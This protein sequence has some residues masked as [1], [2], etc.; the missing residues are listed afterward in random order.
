LL[1]LAVTVGFLGIAALIAVLA[2]GARVL[3]E[4]DTGLTP[5]TIAL[6]GGLAALLV[7]TWLQD[8]HFLAEG[9]ARFSFYRN[10][11]LHIGRLVCPAIVIALVLPFPIPVAWGLAMVGSIVMAAWMLRAMPD[12]RASSPLADAPPTGEPEGQAH[13]PQHR[14]HVPVS[15]FLGTA[16]RNITGSAAEFLPGLLLPPLVLRLQGAEPSAWFYIAWTGASMLFLLSASI[17]R[18]T[19]AEMS[20]HGE[21]AHARYLRQALRHHKLI[22]LPA[23]VLALLTAPLVLRLFGAS[24]LQHGLTVFVLLASSIV[25]IVPVYLYLA[26][27]RSRDEHVALVLYPAINITLL[28]ALAYVLE[29]RF[30]LEGIGLAWILAHAPL[31]LFAAARLR[32][33][34][35]EPVEEV[36]HASPEALPAHRRAPHLE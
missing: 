9:E 1:E 33:A 13:A 11:V 32:K 35:R 23:A 22:V 15:S 16:A 34:V 26:L 20:R 8:A 29:P 17:A 28:F 27:L 36:T 7:V 6:V 5:G 12:H 14:E 31:A 3:G 2:V 30:G 19:F 18:S 25:L 24:Y 10:L 4:A 21:R